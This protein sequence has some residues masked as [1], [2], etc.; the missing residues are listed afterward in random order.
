MSQAN[1]KATP[2]LYLSF[3][4]AHQAFGIPIQVVREIVQLPKI[5]EVPETAESIAGIIRLRDKVIPVVDLRKKF[6]LPVTPYSRETC[7]IV[8]DSSEGLVA[9]I[10]DTVA[11]VLSF[12][13]QNLE[14]AP[15]LIRGK[16]DSAILGIGKTAEQ[17][18]ILVDVS[19]A[20]EKAK[21]HHI[22]DL[23]RLELNA[24]AS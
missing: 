5:T 13:A 12:E 16:S 17:V 24:K 22:E 3:T 19:K 23:S 1:D 18:Y 20:V 6:N 8:V 21:I 14:V 7:V 10:V 4:L 9:M 15:S 11:S 2:A